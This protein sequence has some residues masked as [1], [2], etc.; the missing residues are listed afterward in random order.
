MIMSQNKVSMND[1][2]LREFVRTIISEELS[3]LGRA[4]KALFGVPKLLY[5]GTTVTYLK[6]VIDKTGGNFAHVVGKTLAGPA[7]GEVW[8]ETNA[9]GAVGW[10]I[11]FAGRYKDQPVLLIVAA[12]SDD[13]YTIDR[14]ITRGHGFYQAS[15]MPLDRYRVVPIKIKDGES[16]SSWKASIAPMSIVSLETIAAIKQAERSLLAEVQ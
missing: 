14:D 5:H 12:P 16:A 7:G 4:D 1:D 3:V 6:K 9:A 2:L 10:G 13:K 11:S 8:L 15:H